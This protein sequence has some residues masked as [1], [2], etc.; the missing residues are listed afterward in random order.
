MEATD[1]SPEALAVAK[2]N[3]QRLGAPVTFL[4]GDLWQAVAG[5]CYDLI[6]S[7]PPYIPNEACET[8]QPEVMREPAMAL[9]G[10]ADGLDFYRRI[11]AGVGEHLLPGGVLFLEV[12]YGQAAQVADMLGREGL[13]TECHQDYQGIL[14][15]VEAWR[16]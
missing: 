11:A 5:R 14:R 13:K 2:E 8:L 6:V 15:M 10:G 9:R 4:Q 16:K 1:L 7:N 3:A 12:G